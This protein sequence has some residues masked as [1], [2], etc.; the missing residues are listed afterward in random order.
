MEKV[1]TGAI[2]GTGYLLGYQVTSRVWKEK[3]VKLT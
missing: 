2:V 3:L 1:M